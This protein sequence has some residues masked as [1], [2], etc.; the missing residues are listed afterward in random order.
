V[1]HVFHC[2]NFWDALHRSALVIHSFS[3]V[4]IVP[5]PGFLYVFRPSHSAPYFRELVI[6]L[7]RR[8]VPR[9]VQRAQLHQPVQ[10]LQHQQRQL[11]LSVVVWV[12]YISQTLLLTHLLFIQLFIKTFITIEK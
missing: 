4:S 9:Q 6:Q 3:M 1:H 10:P 5:A 12:N 2:R 7:A 11:P 8:Q